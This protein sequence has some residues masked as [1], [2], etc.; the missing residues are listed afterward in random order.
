MPARSAKKP[1]K[2]LEAIDKEPDQNAAAFVRLALATGMRRGAL[3]ALRWE[4]IDFDKNFI[5]LRG[6][7][8]KNEKTERIPLSQSA[9]TILSG[10]S[11]S[12]SPFVFPGRNGGQRRDF[13][14]I[15][16][17]VKKNAG[18]PDDFRPLHG[19]RH[20]FASFLASSGQVDMYTL[21][22]MWPLW[23]PS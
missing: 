7:A 13:R 2:Y 10:V 15:A 21:T 9:R 16:E 1:R 3:M 14:K 6:V 8:A 20:A 5:M 19:L 4:G 22:R 17:R 18:L 11:R 23:N 12:D